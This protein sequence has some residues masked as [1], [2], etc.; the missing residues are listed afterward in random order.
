MYPSVKGVHPVKLVEDLRRP[1]RRYSQSPL[2]IK[3][4]FLQNLVGSE[5]AVTEP[6]N[7]SDQWGPI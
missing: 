3:V 2:P 4:G 5:S 6:L 7:L 1:K